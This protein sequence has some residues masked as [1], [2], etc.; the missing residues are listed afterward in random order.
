MKRAARLGPASHEAERAQLGIQTKSGQAGGFLTQ[1]VRNYSGGLWFSQHAFNNN[2]RN[3]I[4]SRPGVQNKM[5]NLLPIGPGARVTEPRV[6]KPK[7]KAS[8]SPFLQVY[9]CT[10]QNVDST[11]R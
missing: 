5:L 6:P 10:A 11:G 9:L 3:L 1:T 7:K 8:I 4:Y 2:N